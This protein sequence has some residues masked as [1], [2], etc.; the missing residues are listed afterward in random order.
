MLQQLDELR[1]ALASVQSDPE[2]LRDSAVQFLELTKSMR[3]KTRVASESLNALNEKT[4]ELS[5][6]SRHLATS[7][8]AL[9]ELFRKKARDYS[10]KK[11]REQMLGFAKDYDAIAAS[12]PDKCKSL[13][14][15]QKK[16]PA[17]K[18]FPLTQL[19][20]S[21]RD[22]GVFVSSRIVTVSG[23]TWW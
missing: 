6:A 17:L 20:S 19:S 1:S 15:V 4:S 11:L 5:R 3:E 18:R 2:R 23:R 9:A 8:R 22:G 12:I 16:L 21:R 10:E 13:D 14:A 7:Y